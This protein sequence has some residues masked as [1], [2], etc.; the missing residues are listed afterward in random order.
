MKRFIAF[1]ELL[2]YLGKNYA[3]ASLVITLAG[4]ATTLSA[5]SPTDE[6]EAVFAGELALLSLTT[7][8]VP[9]SVPDLPEPEGPGEIDEPKAPAPKPAKPSVPG[10][11][12]KQLERYDRCGCELGMGCI[13][14]T[15]GASCLCHAITAAKVKQ[16]RKEVSRQDASGQALAHAG[17]TGAAKSAAGR[18]AA[19]KAKAGCSSWGSSSASGRTLSRVVR[20]LRRANPL[21]LF[22]RRR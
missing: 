17:A 6:A 18:T 7:P 2:K 22:R 8:P 1:L 3:W 15:N 9:P 5:D 14:H 19:T 10:F 4:C 16:L 20:P 11:T 12:A 13:C 21:R